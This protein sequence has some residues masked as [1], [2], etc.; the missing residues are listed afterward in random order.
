MSPGVGRSH[1]AMLLVIGSALFM[2]LS[3]IVMKNEICLW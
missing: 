1:A 2:F 3:C